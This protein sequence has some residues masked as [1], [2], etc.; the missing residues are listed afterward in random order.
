MPGQNRSQ[1]MTNTSHSENWHGDGLAIEVRKQPI[2]FIG[3]FSW[4]LFFIP[5]RAGNIAVFEKMRANEGRMN[6]H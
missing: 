4:S 6:P 5:A 2:D 1:F 3:Y